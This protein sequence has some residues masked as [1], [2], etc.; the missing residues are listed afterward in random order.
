MKSYD[1]ALLVL[2]LIATACIFSIFIVLPTGYIPYE[3]AGDVFQG[4][5]GEYKWY[6]FGAAVLLLFVVIRLIIGTFTGNK[7]KN[8]GIIRNTENGEV[9]ISY[10]T[11]KS[12]VIKTIS[13]VKGVK[14]SKV[15][16]YPAEE[17]I[18]IM[19]KTYIMSDVNIPQTVKEIQ[20]NVKAY[21][22]AI[23]EV[24]VGE[25]KVSIID[26]APTTKLRL[27]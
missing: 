15:L 20:E 3:A 25:V 16:I 12:L 21:I 10:D 17:S 27:E 22:E 2:F 6:Y 18:K 23:A 7:A 1:K 26:V 5:M 11:I 9:N 24:P 8:F 4:I 19:I 14:E 13:N